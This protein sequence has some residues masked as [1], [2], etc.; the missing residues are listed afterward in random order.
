MT[1]QP[2]WLKDISEVIKTI[3]EVA[4]HCDQQF[5][6][7]C[8]ELLLNHTLGGAPRAA[9][10]AGVGI[11]TDISRRFLNLLKEH[12]I[13]VEDLGQIMDIEAGEVFV[14]DLGASNAE[15]Q[16]KLAALLALKNYALDGDPLFQKEELRDRCR[17]LGFYDSANFSTNIRDFEYENARVFSST[18][19]GWRVTAPGLRYV[20]D[21]VRLLVG[22]MKSG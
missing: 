18:E 6:A 14:A 17:T 19:D 3:Q 16:R 8:F 22:R 15:R 12:E 7:K 5:Q 2:E 20:A 9:G 1:N 13:D 10:L 4:K 11:P 21:T